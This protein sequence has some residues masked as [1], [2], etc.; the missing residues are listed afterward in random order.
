MK[1]VIL[2]MAIFAVISTILSLIESFKT[3]NK[4]NEIISKHNLL[5]KAL[6][7]DLQTIEKEVENLKN[8]MK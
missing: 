3:R 4:I 1:V 5:A 8:Q 2:S 6:A 7:C